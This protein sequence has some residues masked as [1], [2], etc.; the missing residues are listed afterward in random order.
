MPP[1]RLLRTAL[2]EEDLIEICTYIAQDN[3]MPPSLSRGM[4]ARR[5][6]CNSRRTS[7]PAISCGLGCRSAARRRYA[8]V[9]MLTKF[10]VIRISGATAWSQIPSSMAGRE[11]LR[12]SRIACKA[13]RVHFHGGLAE[14]KAFASDH[15]R[16]LYFR[17]ED[18]RP[19]YEPSTGIA[20]SPCSADCRAWESTLGALQKCSRHAGDLARRSA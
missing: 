9:L 18:R 5:R 12:A 6:I 2:A 16:F 10:P 1:G 3:S 14:P 8:S 19:D 7:A 20:R 4:A 11:H 13:K 15:S 17:R